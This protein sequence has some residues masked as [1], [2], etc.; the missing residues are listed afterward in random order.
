[1]IPGLP[2]RKGDYGQG[3][4]GVRRQAFRLIGPGFAKV[5]HLARQGR[6]LEGE[7]PQGV[8]AW[9]RRSFPFSPA[10]P[11]GIMEGIRPGRRRETPQLPR[12][13]KTGAEAGA[14]IQGPEVTEGEVVSRQC[15]VISKGR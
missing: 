6:G 15:S 14:R 4:P 2:G 9:G 13:S 12:R 10:F 3:P 5:N 11:R 8:E 1:M 7:G